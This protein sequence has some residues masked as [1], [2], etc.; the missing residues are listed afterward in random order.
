[1]LVR[2]LVLGLLA[3]CNHQPTIEKAKKA[4]FDYADNKT[5]IHPDLRLFVFGAAATHD[6][7]AVKRLQRIYETAESGEAQ[8]DAVIAMGQTRDSKTWNEAFTYGISDA[9]VRGQ[10][11]VYLFAGSAK[12]AHN[13]SWLWDFFRKHHERCSELMGGANGL[14]FQHCFETV[15]ACRYESDF[16]KEFEVSIR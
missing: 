2:R 6:P 3:N 8:R 9:K 12:S 4:F 13:Q 5:P 10:D 14:L 1:M 11:I 16:A 7:S 15:G